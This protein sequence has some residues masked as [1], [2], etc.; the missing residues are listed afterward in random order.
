MVGPVSWP[1]GRSVSR[2]VGR[3]VSRS[4]DRPINRPAHRPVGRSVSRSGDRPVGGSGK[5]RTCAVCVLPVLI[6]RF[7][8][9]KPCTK[10][11]N[12]VRS[13]QSDSTKVARPRLR[14]ESPRTLHR[15][16]HR[17][18]LQKQATCYDRCILAA[19]AEATAATSIAAE[20]SAVGSCLQLVVAALLYCVIRCHYC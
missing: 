12:P 5:K 14:G 19:A 1:V 13:V 3:S 18:P 15:T 9:R 2:P 10:K 8:A 16:P 6:R 17:T 20:Y 4:V 11:H 7:G